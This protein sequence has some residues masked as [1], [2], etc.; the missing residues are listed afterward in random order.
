MT[1]GG[2]SGTT[3]GV[4]TGGVSRQGLGDYDVVFSGDRSSCA[5]ATSLVGTTPGQISANPSVAG[6]NTTV[7]VR[8]FDTVGAAADRAFHV[9]L[10]C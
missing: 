7:D 3:R 1:A 10:D 8:T 4:T 6:G 9:S 2:G 5:I